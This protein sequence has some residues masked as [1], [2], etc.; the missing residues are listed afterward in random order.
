M[1]TGIVA[2]LG[3]L[4]AS[5][6]VG[7]DRRL[8][9]DTG[10]LDLSDVGLGD[11]IATSGVCLTVT[12]LDAGGFSADVSNETLAHSTLGTLAPGA[13]LNLEKA[14]AVGERLGGHLVSGHVDGVGEV[15]SCAQEARSLRLRLRAPAA[16]ARYIAIK[17]SICVD[18]VS[19]T[20]NR[21]SGA[22]FELN[23]VP[24]TARHTIMNAYRPGQQVN[25]EVDVIARYVERLLYSAEVYSA[26]VHSAEV[27]SVEGAS[28]ASLDRAT[29]AR[30]GFLRD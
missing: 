16:M 2:A 22:E 10:E 29:L 23:V 28:G 11:S 25:L 5:E 27:H 17:G 1:F 24:H 9:I 3:R 4:R 26:E 13:G 20:V 19:L 15:L 14:L 30:Y 21:V 12:D 18:G 8:R 6:P 7:G